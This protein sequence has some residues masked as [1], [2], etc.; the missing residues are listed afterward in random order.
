MKIEF[1]VLGEPQGK[2]RPKFSRHGTYV[3]V[4]TP[5]KTKAYEENIKASFWEQCGNE[6]FPE[7]SQL[8]LNVYAYFKIPKNTSKKKKAVMLSGEIRPTKKPDIDNIL[9]VVADALNG[10]CYKDDKCIVKMNGEKY[11]ADV[12]R[13]E[14]VMRT[15]ES[16]KLEVKQ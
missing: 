3:T 4:R 16:K 2:A 7:D 15:V 12:P 10:V 14:V 13:I 5:E 1:T 9:K 11:Y 8:A 6:K